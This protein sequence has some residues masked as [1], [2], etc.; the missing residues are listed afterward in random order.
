[1]TKEFYLSPTPQILQWL[2]AGQLGN[3]I[4]RSL[5]LWV[6]IDKL[7]SSQTNWANQ[8]PTP[9]TYSQMRDRLF[10][11]RHPKSDK[12]NAQQIIAQCG[13]QNC[14]CH[15][16]FSDI[17]FNRNFPQT[18]SQ[19]QHE[20]ILLTGINQQQLEKILQ[21]HPF[22][23]VHRSLRDDLKQLI[24]LG[25]LQSAAQGK[26]QCL[27]IEELP[28]P[29][30]PPTTSA[31]LPSNYLSQ[32][33]EKQTWELLRVLESVSF[34]QPNLSSIINQL[35]EQITDNSSS[36]QQLHN[37]EPPPR[38]F[39]HLDYI[40]SKPMQDQVDNYQEQIEQLWHKPPGG[41]VQFEYWIAAT[42]SKVTVTVYPVCLHY[43]RRAKYLSAYGIDP[44]GNVAWHNYRLDRIASQQLKVLPWGDRF[45]PQ[46][47]KQMRNTGTL[48]TP[49]D[50]ARE[51]KA[52]WGFNFYFPKE[53]LILRFPA[54]FAR[55]YVDNT[56]RH[57]TFRAVQ[58]EELPHL[59]VKNIPDQQ[60]CEDLLK[61]VSQSSR[62]DSYY[63][64]WIRIRDIN[65]YMRLREWR[66][67][68]E[69]IAPLSIR[70]QMKAEAEQE[71]ENY[72]T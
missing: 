17:L 46:Q 12:L 27:A 29:P 69:V 72:Q 44:N 35:W 58:Y 39:L 8:L 10:A 6:L 45:V 19:W 63:M 57:E 61:I 64:A 26:Y 31:S 11:Y 5:R 21:E 16:T 34:V 36:K 37:Q 53:L 70:Y 4:V 56:T 60:E 51:L 65:V 22:A 68:G 13:E 62:E 1:M 52:A 2:A 55:W 23:T 25:W 18:E 59:I 40:L 14:I 50:I 32:L 20:I 15:Q 47:L 43:V 38:I 71:L 41:V 54:D 66:P 30:I 49:E 67:N 42:E 48:P 3:R 24:K 7:Y 28:T 9:F 33:T